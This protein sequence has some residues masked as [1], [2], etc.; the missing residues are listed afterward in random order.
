MQLH[1]WILICFAY[2]GSTL[3]VYYG[4][5][6]LSMGRSLSAT[7][8]AADTCSANVTLL[9]ST[10]L[11]EDE[12][13]FSSRSREILAAI[14]EN[15]ENPCIEELH[16]MFEK[17]GNNTCARF[18]RLLSTVAPEAAV[19]KLS[20]VNIHAEPMYKDLLDYANTLLIGRVVAMANADTVFDESLG[21]LKA[22][23]FK[24]EGV[25]YVLSVIPPTPNGKYRERFGDECNATS[26]ENASYDGMTND[27][28]CVLG[29]W[30][31][32]TWGQSY[33]GDSWDAYIFTSPL[34]AT[35]NTRRLNFQTHV[36]GAENRVLYELVV[37]GN[38]KWYNPCKHIRLQHWHCSA[39]KSHGK[40]M[41]DR[42][43][44][45][46]SGESLYNMYPCWDCPGLSLT[47]LDGAEEALLCQNG[48]R[49]PLTASQKTL[50]RSW[51]VH[52][53]FFCCAD[54]DCEDIDVAS[55]PMCR[56]TADTDCVL[57]K[58]VYDPVVDCADKGRCYFSIGDHK[59]V[60]WYFP[61]DHAS[62]MC[63][64]ACRNFTQKVNTSLM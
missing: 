62:P 63:D 27:P 23:A 54:R 31:G 33:A 50:F 9:T 19:S 48:T 7:L 38:M 15:L 44:L 21:I 14:G 4:E 64:K 13:S 36:M 32:G 39:G 5:E 55:R 56:T 60:D 8:G 25:G 12:Y 59:P 40:W 29:A 58:T 52:N 51:Q 53:M 45:P 26:S 34:P 49:K 57:W 30:D 20:C 42:P 24:R 2:P 22:D 41:K 1:S 6:A 17:S 11:H 35:V 10:F 28:R 47:N 16:L 46:R 18:Q 43:D 37:H 61:R 3:T